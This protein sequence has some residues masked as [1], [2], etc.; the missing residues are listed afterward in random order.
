MPRTNG[1]PDV[2]DCELRAIYFLRLYKGYISLEIFLFQ[3]LGLI[4]SE[5]VLLFGKLKMY[6]IGFQSLKSLEYD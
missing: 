3:S 2:H 6:R 5:V 4:K 1:I